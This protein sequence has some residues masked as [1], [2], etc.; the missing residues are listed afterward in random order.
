MFNEEDNIL[1]AYDRV[2]NIMSTTNYVYEI[3]FV[4]DGSVDKS[5]TIARELCLQNKNIR[6]INL[7]RNFGQEQA[8][9]AG[10]KLARGRCVISLDID[11]QE[12]PEIIPEMLKNWE[13]G[14]KI[15]NIKRRSRKEGF[16]KKFTAKC[17]FKVME[18]FGVKNMSDIAC[19][20]LLD[21][22]VVDQINNL[23]ESGGA[24]KSTIFWAGYKT[25]TL[26]V[27]RVER[28]KGKTSYTLEKLFKSASLSMTNSTTKPLYLGF[29][30]GVGL[31]CTTLILCIL[32]LILAI[33]KALS[34]FLWLIPI[35]TMLASILSFILGVQ[36]IYL[37][38]T[39]VE[40]RRRPPYIIES[41]INFDNK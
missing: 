24:F 4:N 12:P 29:Y 35:M 23:D 11:C 1:S 25:K 32:F 22:V 36:G 31:G 41:T 34:P 7:S 2:V 8:L 19:F 26:Y 17:Y 40:S 3:I 16:F 18:K 9:L 14:Y 38:Q 37:S 13:E 21:R 6:L 30:A 28:E 20:F 15:V 5:E 33:C 27:D 39:F 10:H